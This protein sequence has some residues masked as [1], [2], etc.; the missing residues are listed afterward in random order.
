MRD[1]EAGP[2]TGYMC[3]YA[4]VCVCTRERL[5]RAGALTHKDPIKQILWVSASGQGEEP[6]MEAGGSV[7]AKLKEWGP[8]LQSVRETPAGRPESLEN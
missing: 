6:L 3:A 4:R 2:W 7:G 1:G 5:H 8:V